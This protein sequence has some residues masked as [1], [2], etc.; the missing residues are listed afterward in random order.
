LQAEPGQRPVRSPGVGHQQGCGRGGRGICGGCME[1]V[2]AAAFGWAC[3]RRRGRMGRG[4]APGRGVRPGERGHGRPCRAGEGRLGLHICS[5]FVP[6][7][8]F[9]PMSQVRRM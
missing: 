4:F 3:R 7:S 1:F 9:L 2:Q 5:C 8:P 6:N